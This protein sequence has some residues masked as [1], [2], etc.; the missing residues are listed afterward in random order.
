MAQQ[1]FSPVPNF[2]YIN[3]CRNAKR[4]KA[5]A[6]AEY[7]M[8][9]DLQQDHSLRFYQ[10]SWRLG[11]VSTAKLWIDEFHNEIQ[12][13]INAQYESAQLKK[14]KT[15]GIEQQSTDGSTTVSK[16]SKSKSNSKS[17]NR[18]QHN[19][20]IE[21]QSTDKNSTTSTSEKDQ[22]N[23][24]NSKIEQ[25]IYYVSSSYLNTTTTTEDPLLQEFLNEKSKNKNNPL[26]YK[27]SI[28]K[29]IEEGEKSYV[30][31][32]NVWKCKKEIYV[33]NIFL[34]SLKMKKLLVN[35]ELQ[36]ISD[37]ELFENDKCQIYFDNSTVC[38]K[39]YDFLFN[40]FNQKNAS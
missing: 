34:D 2:Y 28:K 25:S 24:E 38:Q 18:T 11:S 21:Q 6:F 23:T 31:E 39:T 1:N 36:T 37:V 26:G 14:Q 3:L 9:L 19:E 13:Y 32:F 5:R 10:K 35:D 30:E 33:K 15:I 40:L 20:D 7:C 27:F 29:K 22:S 17:K 16:F 8:D 4:D 12:K